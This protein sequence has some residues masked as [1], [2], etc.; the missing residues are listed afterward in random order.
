MNDKLDH[1]FEAL[2][3][4]PDADLP[5]LE[6]RV[7]TRIDAWRQSRRASNALVPLRAV[8]VVAA[9]GLGMVGGSLAARAASHSPSE[10][11]AFSVDAHLAP[12]TLLG[13]R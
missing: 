10:V 6:G 7:W 3:Q 1:L 4:E 8:S 5:G 9:L 2:R 11:S 12:S 13:R